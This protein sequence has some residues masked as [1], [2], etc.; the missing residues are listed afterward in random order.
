M[1]T[2]DVRSNGW[3][4]NVSLDELT[5]SSGCNEP[6]ILYISDSIVSI[7]YRDNSNDGHIKSY[8]ISSS[9]GITYT[10]N[11]LSI[12]SNYD[13][14][15]FIHLYD[16]K[17]AVVYGGSSGGIIKTFNISSYGVI[18][19]TGKSYT[20][21]TQCEDPDITWINDDL[22]AIAYIGSGG[23]KIRTFFINGSGNIMY[24]GNYYVFF[25][26]CDDPDIFK[27]SNSTIAVTFENNI[28]DGIVRTYNID[29]LGSISYTGNS[30]QFEDDDCHDPDM[31]DIYSDVY[32][33]TYEGPNGHIG[34][35][36]KVEITSTGQIIQLIS[37]RDYDE[38][39]GCESNIIHISDHILMVTYRKKTPHPGGITTL[40]YASDLI[41]PAYHAGIYKDSSYGIFANT[42]M[43]YGYINNQTISGSISN[44]WNHI[45]LIYDQSTM[46]LYANGTLITSQSYSQTINVNNN[47]V[48]FGN[49]FH[50]MI[51]EIAIYDRAL[52]EEEIIEHFENPGSF[53]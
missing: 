53:S 40:T 39:R 41:D 43:A 32:A 48:L 36:A 18:S 23:D 33:I 45:V 17:Y 4:A 20:F 7:A 21:D 34:R 19:Y 1:K 3:I 30:L 26:G 16:D 35:I 37:V 11:S 29:G 24:S 50:G 27:V 42:T 51:D 5:F 22:Y 46:A 15:S 52:S 47:E 49:F 31:I 25:N 38:D 6:K 9:G 10:G 12:G 44:G 8:S 13:E 2:L 14:L 28:K